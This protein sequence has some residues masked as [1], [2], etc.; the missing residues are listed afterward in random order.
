MN[1]PINVDKAL[2]VIWFCVNCLPLFSITVVLASIGEKGK[3]SKSLWSLGL[4]NVLEAKCWLSIGGYVLFLVCLLFQNCSGVTS[5][6]SPSVFK[7]FVNS[8]GYPS[9]VT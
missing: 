8:I 2:V 6:S 3:W 4:S 5:V 9:L 1:K 7:S